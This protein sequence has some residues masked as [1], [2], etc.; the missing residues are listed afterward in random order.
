MRKGIVLRADSRGRNFCPPSRRTTPIC[1]SISKAARR[2]GT[3][4]RL[5]LNTTSVLCAQHVQPAQPGDPI[6]ARNVF[7]ALTPR[8]QGALRAGETA[9]STFA[10]PTTPKQEPP[11]LNDHLTV[12][13]SGLLDTVRRPQTGL[14]VAA[15]RR[16]L[17][18]AR[19]SPV[20]LRPLAATF[21]PA[22]CAA[23]SPYVGGTCAPPNW[24]R[25]VVG[26]HLWYSGHGCHV[27]DPN[28]CLDTA[29]SSSTGV[30]TPL[31]S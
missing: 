30:W 1:E 26:H 11:V 7:R 21:S 13:C 3:A 27:G 8:T 22:C 4:Q 14:P 20:T 16:S 5:S 31:L 18:A 25:S 6:V 9:P 23:A 24:S 19:F 2:A 29:S 17:S 28:R 10:T 15:L 12:C